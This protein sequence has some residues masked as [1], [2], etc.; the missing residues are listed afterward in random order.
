MRLIWIHGPPASGKLSVAR[1]LSERIGAGVLHNHLSIDLARPVLDFEDPGFWPLVDELRLA[2]VR[3]AAKSDRDA[4]IYTSCYDHP[5]DLP[6]V[7]EFEEALE[8][9][10]GRLLPVYL[11]CDPIELERRVGNP[12]RREVGKITSI[13]K[14]R[15][16]LA[17]WNCIAM[18]R[19]NCITVDTSSGT[20]RESA[21]AIAAALEG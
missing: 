2:C 15:H 5:I 20:P 14:L 19:E 18:P 6:V 21:A 17:E 9:E 7:E 10:G 3:A 12:D 11:R 13:P 16:T 1:A 8:R 4:L